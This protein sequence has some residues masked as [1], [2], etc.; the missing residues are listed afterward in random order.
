MGAAPAVPAP[1][2]TEPARQG[3]GGPPPRVG[4]ATAGGFQLQLGG[5]YGVRLGSSWNPWRN[6]FGFGVGYTLP[7]GLYLGLSAEL[8]LG[9]TEEL[10]LDTTQ[11]TIRQFSAE[12]GYDIAVG[13]SFVIRPKLG[14]GGAHRSS[15]H[16]RCWPDPNCNSE[17][18]ATLLT[19]GLTPMA[20]I[21]PLMGLRR[22]S[23]CHRVRG[24]G[25]EG[26]AFRRWHRLLVVSPRGIK[27]AVSI[28]PAFVPG[29]Y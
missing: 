18:D 10:G 5:V 1:A 17:D 25:A 8:Y 14:L 22:R 12:L 26:A 19:L 13:E 16:T 15:T 29:S 23:L 27:K 24:S 11:T 4:P 6:G 28:A 9:T 21:T 3:Q 7:V 20:F 2:P